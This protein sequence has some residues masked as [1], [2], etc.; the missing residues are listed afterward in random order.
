[1]DTDNARSTTHE[2]DDIGGLLMETM[3][4]FVDYVSS[5]LRRNSPI[6]N[7]AHFGVLRALRAAPRALHELASLHEV[8]LPT[9]SRTIDALEG[10]EWVLRTRSDR[11][12]RSV[13]ISITNTGLNVLQ[14]VETTAKR[15][16]ADALA[17]LS[18]EDLAALE[19]GVGALHTVLTARAGYPKPPCAPEEQ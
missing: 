9:M 7:G 12:R 14:E 17:D 18:S 5:Y 3:P 10:R 11:D 4:V 1:M 13:T 16:A 6:D 15:R 19:R 8:R 2:L